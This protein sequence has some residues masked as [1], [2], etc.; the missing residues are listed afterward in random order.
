MKLMASL[1]P[2]RAEDETGV[3]AKADP[4]ISCHVSFCQYLD[5]WVSCL[6]LSV[7]RPLDDTL[8]DIHITIKVVSTVAEQ[9]KCEIKFDIGPVS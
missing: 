2:A 6:L 3:M 7:S 9:I 8:G 5:H 4:K 1:A